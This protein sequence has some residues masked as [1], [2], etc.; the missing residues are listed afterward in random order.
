MLDKLGHEVGS[1][2]SISSNDD[3]PSHGF[4][5]RLS[6]FL[7]TDPTDLHTPSFR[8]KQRDDHLIRLVGSDVADGYEQLGSS[9]L[10]FPRAKISRRLRRLSDW[11]EKAGL[12]RDAIRSQ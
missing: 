7:C 12:P 8:T 3:D 6:T 2:M 5:L 9:P 4:L 1:H 11:D 10:A